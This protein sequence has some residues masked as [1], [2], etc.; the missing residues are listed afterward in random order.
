V[1]NPPLS[2]ASATGVVAVEE[3]WILSARAHPT[4][5]G[6][7]GVSPSHVWVPESSVGHGVMGGSASVSALARLHD[8]YHDA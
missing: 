3:G 4:H 6:V 2:A 5:D 1:V 7:L 8:S